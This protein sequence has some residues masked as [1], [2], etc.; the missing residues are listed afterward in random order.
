MERAGPPAARVLRAVPRAGHASPG[1][2]VS[3]RA[4]APARARRVARAARPGT[5]PAAGPR[6]GPLLR[7]GAAS[8]GRLG[9]RARLADLAL[10]PGAQPLAR[11]LLVPEHVD[12]GLDAGSLAAAPLVGD[13]TPP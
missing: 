3:A 9:G 4:R 2:E 1:A 10:G 12:G 7:A 8:V 6:R 13:G 5:G 11:H